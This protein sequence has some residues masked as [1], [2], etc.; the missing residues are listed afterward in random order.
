MSLRGVVTRPPFRSTLAAVLLALCAAPFAAL[1]QGPPPP[2]NVPSVLSGVGSLVVQV[3]ELNGTPVT[4]AVL[5]LYTDTLFP[6]GNTPTRRGDGFEFQGL[7]PGRYVVEAT[8]VG[9]EQ[10]RQVVELSTVS[11]TEAVMLFLKPLGSNRNTPYAPEAT[12]L[13]PKAQKETQSALRD[14]HSKK[15]AGAQKH[16]NAALRAAPDNALV[17]Y[18]IGMTFVWTGRATEAKPY[19]EKALSLDP[20]HGESLLVLGNLRCRDGDYAGAI[21]LLDRAVQLSPTSWQA[22]WML[23]EAHQRLGNFPR[24]REH[25]ERAFELGREKA[26]G[27]QLVLAQALVGLGES[28]Q[29]AGVLSAYLQEHPQDANAEKIRGWIAE[30]KR[31][32][33][34]ATPSAPTIVTLP[35]NT[36]DVQPLGT[37]PVA[38]STR[39]SW[40]PPDADATVP[41]V[42]PGKACSL[43]QVLSGAA[44]RTEELVTDLEQFSALE[45]YESV[46]IGA[47]GQLLNP[48]SAAFKYLVFI[49]KVRPGFLTVQEVRE[50]NNVVTS[51]PERL[52]DLGSPAVVLVF[53][54]NY[55][56]D[57]E[58]K[59]EGLGQ[60]NGQA[61]WLVHFRQR[62]DRPVQLRYFGSGQKGYPM[63]LRGRAWISVESFQVVHLE[64]DLLEPIPAVQLRREHVSI[65][66]QL[67]PFP[68]H[69]RELWLPQQV[70]LYFDF[71]GRFYHHYH[72]FTDFRLFAVDVQQK[73][74]N[75]KEKEP[76]P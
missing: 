9:F 5:T 23:A 2:P 36:A 14:L 21:E 63:R 49:H 41:P 59:C 4:N 10:A 20:K 33:E 42:L 39:D 65:D 31:P 51:L 70:D 15:F 52:Q 53:H 58:M 72:R 37:L 6:T 75:P 11:Q 24:A 46:E 64:T 60:W 27:A 57:F 26:S 7:L 17:H 34:D 61:A 55:Q 22:H 73:I 66:Y 35:L 74:A 38:P 40:A 47:D 48:I 19:F 69:K 44:K 76:Q 3:K 30:L 45:H 67:V 16:L 1:P 62:P 25:A 8:M 43:P 13:T 50:Q 28:K 32:T 54:P 12:V 68:K 18:L 29:A 71:R 56:D